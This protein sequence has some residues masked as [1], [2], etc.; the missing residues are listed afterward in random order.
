TL[1]DQSARGG[2]GAGAEPGSRSGEAAKR[3]GRAGQSAEALKGKGAAGEGPGRAA[4]GGGPINLEA[5]GE[6]LYGSPRPGTATARV[7][8]SAAY[9]G[10][11]REAERSVQRSQV[12][13]RMRALIRNYFDAINPDAEKRP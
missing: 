10:Y 1:F 13:P 3:Y 7:P 5:E 12:P 4:K 6:P 2:T 8:Y 9:P 11:R